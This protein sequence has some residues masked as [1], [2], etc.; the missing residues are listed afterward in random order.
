M[1]SFKTEQEMFWAGQFGDDYVDRNN[2]ADSIAANIALFS[3]ILSRTDQVNSVLELGANLGLNL[4]ALKALRPSAMF[5]AV[6]INNK[7]IEHLQQLKWL[8]SYHQS[9]LE[10]QAKSEYDL[11]LIKGVLIHINPDFL[12]K[13]Y[14]LLYQASGKYILVIEYFN[15]VPVEVTYRGHKNKLFKRDF[16]G[17]LLDKHPDLKLVD[18]GFS[19]HRDP[20]FPQDNTTWF[21]MKKTT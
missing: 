19:Y 5:S 20:N 8:Q 21:L 18:Y 2:G 14:N 1:R 7:A 15:P 3:K 9:L 11:V 13:V 6:E 16:A 12:D 10:F 4:H 17:D